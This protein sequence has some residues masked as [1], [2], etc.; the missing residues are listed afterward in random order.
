MRVG[1]PKEIKNR[2]R[3]VALT[4]SGVRLLCASGHEVFVQAEAG[5]GSGFDDA[6][7][8]E[9]GAS[10]VTADK[11]WS[12]DLV[13]KVKEPQV[14]EYAY[15]RPGM[16]LFTYLHLAACPGLADVLKSQGVTAIG[17]ETVCD[18]HG[19]LPL[20]APMSHIAGRVAVQMAAHYLQAENDTP[21]PGRG[22]LFGGLPGVA[23][24]HVLVLGGGN[25][26]SHAAMVAAGLGARVTVLEVS[27]VQ[28]ERLRE[29]LPASVDVMPF[30][31]AALEKALGH[32]DVLI[33][34]AL[35]P[36]E[37]AP[38][39]LSR[40][41]LG[42]MPAS[43]VFVDIAI[44]QGG[45]CETSRVTSYA[46]PVYIESGV[47]HCCLPNLPACV[48]VTGTQALTQATMP[49]VQLLADLG[50]ERALAESPALAMGVN[51]RAGAVVH[52]GVA[53]ALLP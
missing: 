27:S 6:Q 22:R 1:V 8:T 5:A 38:K 39:L 21:F 42:L 10:L 48:P 4:P 7:Y 36:G 29:I 18:E 40:K 41:Q 13:L 11:A 51:V 16:L 19:R 50:L 32:S 17:Y 30:T 2:E 25:A 31:E 49:Y 33:G 14:E 45:M 52:P 20:L 46:E 28:I 37:H 34:A 3:R 12:A 26:G 43:S 24:V 44:D 9:A 15:L 35:V 53:K 23:P 47:L